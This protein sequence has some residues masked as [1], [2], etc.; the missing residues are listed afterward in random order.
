ML[1]EASEKGDDF[2]SVPHIGQHFH[3]SNKAFKTPSKVGDFAQLYY[4]LVSGIRYLSLYLPEVFL[5]NSQLLT[6]NVTSFNIVVNY[7]FRGK[8]QQHMNL[9]ADPSFYY[10]LLLQEFHIQI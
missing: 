3:F 2:S 7:L 4:L 10:M 1:I 9:E 6:Y 8:I 5:Y